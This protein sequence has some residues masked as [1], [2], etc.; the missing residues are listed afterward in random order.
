L[1]LFGSLGKQFAAERTLQL[2]APR[3]RTTCDLFVITLFCRAPPIGEGGSHF[4]LGF[5]R[6]H[7]QPRARQSTNPCCATAA[8]V[9]DF[10][11]QP[12]ARRSAH[13]L[14][15]VPESTL[16]FSARRASSGS[17]PADSIFRHFA[18][19]ARASARDK[20]RRGQSPIH[21]RRN[22]N[23]QDFSRADPHLQ[24][25]AAAVVVSAGSMI[26]ATKTADSLF[27]CVCAPNQDRPTSKPTRAKSDVAGTR[28]TCLEDKILKWCCFSALFGR[29]WKVPEQILAEREGFE[30]SRRLPAYTRSRRAPSTTRPPLL[31]KSAAL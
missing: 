12:D 29:Y 24:I 19:L 26:W 10:S 25:Q 1:G 7:A 2:R 23:S 9:S 22:R 6:R 14:K 20:S 21:L 31:G 27:R 30:P 13:C 15:V 28:R 5:L 18:A 16:R 4:R 17:I 3:W 8:G 11:M